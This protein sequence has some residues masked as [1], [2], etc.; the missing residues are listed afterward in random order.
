MSSG[1][2]IN[3]QK[4]DETEKLFLKGAVSQGLQGLK[5]HRSVGGIRASNYNSVS[6]EGAQKLAEY[7]QEFAKAG[8]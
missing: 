1:T 2:D 6:L 5:G 4:G 7:L 3:P 8:Q